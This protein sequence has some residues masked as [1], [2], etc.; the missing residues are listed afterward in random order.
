MELKV[1]MNSETCPGGQSESAHQL[2]ALVENDDPKKSNEEGNRGKAN[3]SE[4]ITNITTTY[5]EG[6][7]EKEGVHME[8]NQANNQKENVDGETF[9]RHSHSKSQVQ[10][11]VV[12][13]SRRRSNIVKQLVLEEE[14]AALSE[15]VAYGKGAAVEVE[16]AR[17][18]MHL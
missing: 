4:L 3:P 10:E 15:N 13:G 6:L 9:T 1:E 18:V 12:T 17:N 11:D 5:H 14:E 2:N 7:L 8:T 16:I